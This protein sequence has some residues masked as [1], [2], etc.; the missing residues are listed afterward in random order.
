[1]KQRQGRM[2]ILESFWHKI[3]CHHQIVS[4]KCGR[5]MQRCSTNR[6]LFLCNGPCF[7][8]PMCEKSIVATSCICESFFMTCAWRMW[9]CSNFQGVNKCSRHPSHPIWCSQW[10]LEIKL[11]KKTPTPWRR[12]RST[13]G[14]FAP[15][16]NMPQ[17][18]TT[19]TPSMVQPKMGGRVHTKGNVLVSE[20]PPYF[21][22]LWLLEEG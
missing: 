20:K 4:C 18:A 8:S 13:D 11:N 7:E 12:C 9:K 2:E 19:T 6:E 5:C 21:P 10:T 14:A 22:H 15:G 1:M 17:H 16:H 3:L